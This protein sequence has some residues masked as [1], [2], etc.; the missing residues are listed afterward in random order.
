MASIYGIQ[1]IDCISTMA[2]DMDC[3][4]ITFSWVF[5]ERCPTGLDRRQ[6]PELS[7]DDIQCPK[8]LKD[9]WTFAR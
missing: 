8:G 3:R 7:N 5:G 6:W 2:S 9:L 1:N 4:V